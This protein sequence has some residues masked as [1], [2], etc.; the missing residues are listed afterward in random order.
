MHQKVNADLDCTFLRATQTKFKPNT[1]KM[2]KEW[3][4][5]GRLVCRISFFE[6]GQKNA[7]KNFFQKNIYYYHP[8]SN[9]FEV[10]AI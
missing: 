10:V 8:L 2:K 3:D 5:N 6:K 4:F 7:Q 9:G 1:P